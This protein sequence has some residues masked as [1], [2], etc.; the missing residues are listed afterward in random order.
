MLP[1][2]CLKAQKSA[3]GPW[4]NTEVVRRSWYRVL[5]KL[6]GPDPS[7]TPIQIYRAITLFCYIF[8]YIRNEQNVLVF[9]RRY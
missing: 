3:R 4:L 6:N 1:C 2:L 5:A 8:Q 9:A 7:L